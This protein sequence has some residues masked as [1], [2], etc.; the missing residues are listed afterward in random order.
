MKVLA[1]Y[2]AQKD[3]KGQA[4]QPEMRRAQSAKRRLLLM[5]VGLT[6]ALLGGWWLA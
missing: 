3:N 4:R 2:P 1:A 5:V 6:C